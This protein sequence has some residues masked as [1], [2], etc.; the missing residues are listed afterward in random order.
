MRPLRVAL[1]SGNYNYLKEGANQALNK[2]VDYL[3][4][5]GHSVRVYSPVTDTPAFEPQGTL[6]PVPS[7]TLPIRTEFQLA[8]GMPASIRRDVERFAPDLIHVSTPDILNTRAETF[9]IRHNIPIVASLHTRFETYPAYYRGLR[10]LVPLAVAQQ[11]RFYRRADCVL[12]PTACTSS[13]AEAARMCCS[14]TLKC[15]VVLGQ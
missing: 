15:Q 13:I 7:I 11:R 1:F 12:A 2:L 5:Q 8:L 10:W 9:A 6:V 14:T 3:G 4:R